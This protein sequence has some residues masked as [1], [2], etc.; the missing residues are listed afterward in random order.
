MGLKKLVRDR[1]KTAG[2]TGKRGPRKLD[3]KKL[4]DRKETEFTEN[5]YLLS[6]DLF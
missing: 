1:F 5:Q 2:F 4:G 6:Q 3:D